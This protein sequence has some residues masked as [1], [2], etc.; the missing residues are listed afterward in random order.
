[1]KRALMITVFVLVYTCMQAQAAPPADIFVVQVGAYPVETEALDRKANLE[2]QGFSPVQIIHVDEWYKVWF[3]E[4]GYYLDA[5]IYKMLLR[6]EIVPD[7]FIVTI[8]NIESIAEFSPPSSPFPALFSFFEPSL[9]AVQD[10][11][12]EFNDRATSPLLALVELGEKELYLLEDSMTSIALPLV[13]LRNTGKTVYRLTAPKEAR[14]QLHD[15]ATSLH[16]TNPVK[17]WIFSRLGYINLIEGD[18]GAGRDILE[19]VANGEVTASRRDR[20]DAMYLVGWTHYVE[21]DRMMAY[22]AFRELELFA[23]DDP[24]RFVFQ[25]ECA[26]LLMEFALSAKGTLDDCRREC[27]KILN[28]APD[29]LR[30]QRAIAELLLLETYFREKHYVTC[31]NMAEQFMAAYPECT[32]EYT[33][34]LCA[35][36]QS[37]GYSG[38]YDRCIEF[39]TEL[40]GLNAPPEERFFHHDMKSWARLWLTWAYEK[41]GDEATAAYWR[42]QTKPWLRG[43]QK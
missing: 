2:S 35:A 28:A 33:A 3:G 9:D 25:V 15:V 5:Y 21:P 43:M 14:A 39:L 22:R 26:G 30:K 19:M 12:V 10:Y 38:Q 24:L 11:A 20:I 18:Y 13:S 27:H 29:A 6:E 36:A 40:E 41:K 1:M 23:G 8:P 42:V 7:A 37:C 32:R 4:F 34:A 17:G 16:D 31:V